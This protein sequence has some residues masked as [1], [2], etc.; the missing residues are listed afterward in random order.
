MI[1][2]LFRRYLVRAPSLIQNWRP[3]STAP[4]HTPAAAAAAAPSAAADDESPYPDD[5]LDLAGDDDDDMDDTDSPEAI[6]R[7][8]QEAGLASPQ[9]AAMWHMSAG[10]QR[11]H[12]AAASYRDDAEDDHYALWNPRRVSPFTPRGQEGPYLRSSLTTFSNSPRAR[13]RRRALLTLVDYEAIYREQDERARRKEEAKA[14]RAAQTSPAPRQQDDHAYAYPASP[15]SP[16]VRAARRA[17]DDSFVGAGSRATRPDGTPTSLSLSAPSRWRT[18]LPGG[19]PN[20][21]K[22][23]VLD[24]DRLPIKELHS[25]FM[26]TLVR[27]LPAEKCVRVASRI[28]ALRDK[29]TQRNYE[30]FIRDVQRE[31]RVNSPS[32]LAYLLRCHQTIAVPYMV[33]YIRKYGHFSRGFIAAQIERSL[34]PRLFDFAR[35]QDKGGIRPLPMVITRPWALNSYV[36]LM[37]KSSTKTYLKEALYYYGH[38]APR[39]LSPELDE[40]V[41]AEV[42]VHEMVLDLRRSQRKLPKRPPLLDAV[43]AAEYTGRTMDEVLHDAIEAD[44]ERQSDDEDDTDTRSGDDQGEEDESSDEEH[45]GEDD[46]HHHHHSRHGQDRPPRRAEQMAMDAP[47]TSD[48]PYEAADDDKDEFYSTQFF[49]RPSPTS[50]SPSLSAHDDDH[51]PQSDSHHRHVT[52][53][54]VA[55]QFEKVAPALPAR[56]VDMASAD[57]AEGMVLDPTMEPKVYRSEAQRA[58]EGERDFERFAERWWKKRRRTHFAFNKK[59]FTLVDGRWQI[60]GPTLA[61]KYQPKKRHAPH[62]VLRARMA[63]RLQ[64]ER[65]VR[66]KLLAQGISTRPPSQELQAMMQMQTSSKQPLSRLSPNHPMYQPSTAAPPA[67]SQQQQQQQQ[68]ALSQTDGAVKSSSSEE[69]GRRGSSETNLPRGVCRM[70]RRSRRPPVDVRS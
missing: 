42:K 65:R 61:G 48:A 11:E 23:K 7:K 37:A 5:L 32:L 50:P 4:H 57:P 36:R 39:H 16:I 49:P 25:L 29:P 60:T 67:S 26:Y 22:V 66:A 34:H 40:T 31:F 63:E 1:F 35:F 8:L 14:R 9:A 17:V 51:H 30:H 3:F 56:Y 28:A 21:Y 20:V 43:L 41:G 64:R 18:R 6:D 24:V 27:R 10:R 68:S 44:G 59:H 33:D 62:T 52:S 13:D 58:G 38:I 55:L 53:Q 2:R 45:Q 47:G 15:V 46:Y 69:I 70:R 19:P 54:S 12:G